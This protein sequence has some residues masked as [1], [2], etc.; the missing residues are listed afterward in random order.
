MTYN[1]LRRGCTKIKRRTLCPSGHADPAVTVVG[2]ETDEKSNPNELHSES[3]SRKIMDNTKNKAVKDAKAAA[4]AAAIADPVADSKEE[5]IAPRSN[6]EK[7]MLVAGAVAEVIEGERE[8]NTQ[9]VI[10]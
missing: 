2:Q 9:C 1:E 10:L 3:L 8:P 4:A 7:T 5:D 6:W